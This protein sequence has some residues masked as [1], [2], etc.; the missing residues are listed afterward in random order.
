VTRADLLTLARAI[1]GDWDAARVQA[2]RALAFAE[3]LDDDTG[4]TVVAASLHHFYGAIESLAER[5]VRAF[6][7][8]VSRGERWHQELLEAASWDIEGVR[9]ALFAPST[10]ADLRVLLRF[11]HFFRHAYAVAWD[12]EKLGANLVVLARVEPLLARDIEAFLEVI[13]TA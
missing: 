13:E 11:R 4:Q 1:R 2:G 5:T 8:T 10:V 9:P 3:R 6:G 7:Q 12:P